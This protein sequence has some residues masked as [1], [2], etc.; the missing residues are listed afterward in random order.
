MLRMSSL[1]RQVQGFKASCP[2]LPWH[3]IRRIRTTVMGED[4]LASKPSFGPLP[5]RIP[6]TRRAARRAA[7]EAAVGRVARRE[8]PHLIIRE[9]KPFYLIRAVA[10]NQWSVG[11]DQ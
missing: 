8:S 4:S 10:S 3:V 11:S 9:L 1:E 6:H 5:T 2:V 7:A